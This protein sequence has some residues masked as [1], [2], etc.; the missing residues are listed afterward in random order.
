[1][2]NQN[3]ISIKMTIEEERRRL[4][5]MMQVANKAKTAEDYA[6]LAKGFELAAKAMLQA[7]ELC[8]DIS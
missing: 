3:A 5:A 4:D 7:Q 1:M 6:H 2:F 8:E